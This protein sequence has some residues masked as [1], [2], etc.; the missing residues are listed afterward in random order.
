MKKKVLIVA[1][2]C[3]MTMVAKAQIGP[4]DSAVQMPTMDLYDTGAM[5]AYIGALAATVERRSQQFDY[6]S[7]LAVDAYCDDRWYDAIRYVNNALSTQY[8]D[9]LLYYIRGYAY[10]Q[11]GNLKEAKKDYKIGKKYGDKYSIE[12]LDSLEQKEKAIRK[13]K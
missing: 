6:F 5:N 7:K 2:V 13:T 10:E 4:Y 12:A 8:Y 9:G 11:L 3:S 1:V